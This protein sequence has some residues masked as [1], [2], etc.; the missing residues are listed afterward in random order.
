MFL[1]QDKTDFFD[2]RQLS[3]QTKWRPDVLQGIKFEGDFGG[4]GLTN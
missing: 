3:K 2:R 1:D 4:I